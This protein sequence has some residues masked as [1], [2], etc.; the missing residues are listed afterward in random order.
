M[1]C[2]W[3]FISYTGC[4][5]K[6]N[7][8]GQPMRYADL[9]YHMQVVPK[10]ED[11]PHNTLSYRYC[12]KNQMVIHIYWRCQMQQQLWIMSFVPLGDGPL[13]CTIFTAQTIK[14]PRRKSTHEQQIRSQFLLSPETKQRI[15]FLDT[16]FC[17]DRL[18]LQTKKNLNWSTVWQKHNKVLFS[19]LMT[20]LTS[21]SLHMKL[22]NRIRP[23][24]ITNISHT[25]IYLRNSI[26]SVK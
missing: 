1:R 24:V 10:F 8:L 7:K 4:S 14:R 21:Q 16:V 11:M 26:I 20:P 17:N 13:H 9:L 23:Y 5:R 15:K 22:C 18:S 12:R 2:K 19:W 25:V 3:S 6:L